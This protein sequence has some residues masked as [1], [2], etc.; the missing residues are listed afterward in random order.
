MVK[1][2][3]VTIIIT[4]LIIALFIGTIIFITRQFASTCPSGQIY[5]KSL[6]KC[7]VQCNAG[8]TYYPDPDKCLQCPPGQKP[9]STGC[10]KAC[11]NDQERCGDIC[12]SSSQK[13]VDGF[14]FNKNKE[15]VNGKF[16]Y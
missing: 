4:L 1:L 7:R 15:W 11:K 14:H 12:C 13:C 5:D 10:L 8:E 16:C 9:S 6:K 3:H 2:T